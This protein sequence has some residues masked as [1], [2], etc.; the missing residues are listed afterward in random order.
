MLRFVLDG[1]LLKYSI[2]SGG[3]WQA[4]QTLTSN[5]ISPED[6]T[7]LPHAASNSRIDISD[8]VFRVYLQNILYMQLTT[9]ALTA[10]LSQIT[11]DNSTYDL[12]LNLKSA[13]GQRFILKNSDT[14]AAM[15]SVS[16]SNINVY[17]KPLLGIAGSMEASS[18]V[19]LN[20]LQ[21]YEPR[22]LRARAPSNVAT[23]YSTQ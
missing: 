15:L 2:Y 23:I 16:A 10:K 8:D 22:S 19:P 6:S 13:L 17:N 3:V 12:V 14:D 4:N 9:S 11:V 1:G 5:T 18:A 20:T 7:T 21:N